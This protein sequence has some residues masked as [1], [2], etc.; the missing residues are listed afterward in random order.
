MPASSKTRIYNRSLSAREATLLG[1]WERDRRIIISLDDLRREVGPAAAT[2]VAE[3]LVKKG[4]LK[5]VAPGNFLIRPLRTQGRSALPSAP[6]FVAALLQG[7][8]F[9]LG[10]L[11]ALTFHRLTDQQFASRIDAFV[12]R[13]RQGLILGGARVIFHR[14]PRK[15]FAAGMADAEVEGVRLHVSTPERTLIDLLDR[16]ALAGGATNALRLVKDTLARVSIDRLIDHAAGEAK[17]STCQRLGLLLERA[18]VVPRKLQPLQRRVR[19]TKSDLSL[20]SGLRR[21]GSFNR[22][23]RVVENDL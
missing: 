7:E 14:R 17:P 21:A 19:E 12:A 1:T 3:R 2:D 16:P 4:I 6:V 13:R 20:V 15:Q 9:Y 18:G 8:P 5:R 11:W 22:R 23:W 10:G